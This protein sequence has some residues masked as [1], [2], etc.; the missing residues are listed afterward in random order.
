MVSSD[1]N[2][3]LL[4]TQERPL[5]PLSLMAFVR[6][7]S[8]IVFLKATNL[9]AYISEKHLLIWFSLVTQTKL[10]AGKQ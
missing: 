8:V 1:L 9:P 4:Q 2:K 10:K 6:K 5:L 3:R 7:S